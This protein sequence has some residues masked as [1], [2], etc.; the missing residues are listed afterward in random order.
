MYPAGCTKVNHSHL[1]VLVL[2]INGSWR[3]PCGN[4]RCKGYEDS[5]L[6]KS[7]ERE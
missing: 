2:T 5:K 1:W 6:K 3:K 4:K 7:S